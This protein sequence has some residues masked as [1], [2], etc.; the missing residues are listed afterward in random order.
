MAYRK[1]RLAALRRYQYG[2]KWKY[3]TLYIITDVCESMYS[4]YKC[5]R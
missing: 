1:P 2:G 5:K 3:I 4:K